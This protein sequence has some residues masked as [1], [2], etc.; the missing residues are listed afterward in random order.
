[1]ILFLYGEDSYRSREKLNQIEEKFKKTDKGRVNLVKI[2]G[3]QTSWKNIEKEILAVPF[4]HDKKLVVIENFL[5]RKGQKFDEAVNFFK[6]KKLPKGTVV[7]FWEEGLPDEH[8]VIFKLLNKPKQAERFNFL[9]GAKLNKWILNE[10]QARGVKIDQ[11]AVI[12]LAE[13]VGP[14]LWQM[15]SELNKLAAYARGCKGKIT[16]NAVNLFVQ[17][18]FDEN[19]FA[20]TDAIGAK[21]DRLAFQLLNEQIEAGLKENYIFAMLVRHFRIL[22]QLKEIVEKNYS[23]ISPN[24]VSIARH[25]AA[26]LGLHPYVVKKG[27]W[28]IKNYS[29]LELKKIYS[30]L[31]AIDMKIKKTNLDIR[32]LLDLFVAQ[33]CSS[34]LD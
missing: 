32:V 6:E 7:V 3:E 34:D 4:L 8:T 23:F 33:V 27:L 26:E 22:L 28:Q 13:L 15:S 11:R 12:L 20:L 21:N 19:I 18:N 1:M 16:V 25:L 14:N 9:E 29:L 31:L 2:D 30:K 24:D 10:V 5:K 17:G